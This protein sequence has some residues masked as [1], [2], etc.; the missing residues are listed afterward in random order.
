M[1]SGS[2]DFPLGSIRRLG[3][4]RQVRYNPAL[5]RFFTEDIARDEFFGAQSTVPNVNGSAIGRVGVSGSVGTI[6]GAT[7]SSTG[8]VGVA[9]NSLGRKASIGSSISRIG[10]SST[11]IGYKNSYGTSIGS[12]GIN[13]FG[14]GVAATPGPAIFGSA[15]G[16]IGIA[17]SVSGVKN[18]IGFTTSAIGISGSASGIA[19]IISS[20]VIVSRGSRWRDDGY[21]IALAAAEWLRRNE[22]LTK[23]IK[24]QEQVISQKETIVESFSEID[25]TWRKELLEELEERKQVLENIRKEIS[26]LK[27]VSEYKRVVKISKLKKKLVM[28]QA[29]LNEYHT[30]IQRITEKYTQRQ[31]E[32]E[33][34]LILDLMEIL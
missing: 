4:L 32:D 15:F 12:V 21:A 8:R 23:V 9:G 5:F 3:R 30:E 27:D 7:G 18:A 28:A 14:S 1:S 17:G 6:K 2:V 29:K 31:E 24:E 13:G 22:D 26:R 25:N 20:E 19:E 16:N 34:I 11:S 33:L 10:V